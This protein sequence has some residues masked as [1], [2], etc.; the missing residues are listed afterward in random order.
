MLKWIFFSRLL[1]KIKIILFDIGWNSSEQIGQQE[2]ACS[3][4]RETVSHVNSS[5]IILLKIILKILVQKS[6]TNRLF[7]T[8]GSQRLANDN[9][10]I[11]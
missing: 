9:Q 3:L 1:L 5:E 11:I 4:I 7:L 8:L 2:D 6:P 10:I